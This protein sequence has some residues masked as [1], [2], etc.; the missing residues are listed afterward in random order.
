MNASAER[1]GF[2]GSPRAAASDS[3]KGVFCMASPYGL[4]IFQNST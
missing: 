1:P 4:Q 3:G 2:Q